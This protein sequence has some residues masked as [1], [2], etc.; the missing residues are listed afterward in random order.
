MNLTD[1]ERASYLWGKLSK[2]INERI[3]KLRLNLEVI[4]QTQEQTM[5]IRGRI[6]E[7]RSLLKLADPDQQK[8]SQQG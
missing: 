6:A 8:N 4:T 1:A 3:E 5:E 2:H 7:L